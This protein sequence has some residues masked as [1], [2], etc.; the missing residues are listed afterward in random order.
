NRLNFRSNLDFQLTPTTK[1]QTN[2]GGSYGVRKTPWGGGNDY[3]FWI[4]AYNNSPDAFI[5]RYS[6]GTWGYHNPSEQAALNSIR[7]LSVSG[8]EYRTTARISTNFAL[9]QKL[10]MLVKGLSFKGTLAID[11]TFVEFGRGVNDL[12]NAF[13]QKWIDPE[14][15]QVFYEEAFDPNT[16]FDF[17]DQSSSW[18]TSGGAIGGDQRRMFYQGQLN[19]TTTV[20]DEH[21]ITAMGSLC[22]QPDAQGNQIPRYREDWVFRTTY[23]YKNKYLIEYNGAYNGSE[24]FGPGYRFAFFSSG[25]LGWTVS[26]ESFMQTLPF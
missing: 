7:I 26:E 14:T 21:N 6:D 5:P 18:V 2:L 20:A 25:G 16:R 4:A 12:Y 10:D 9:E 1:L 23:N 11:N 24:K 13:Q 8:A 22:R 19:Y 15:G 17:Q 3:G